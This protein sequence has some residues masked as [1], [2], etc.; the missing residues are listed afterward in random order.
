ML[1]TLVKASL[2]LAIAQLLVLALRHASAAAKH[3]LLTVG[4]AAF[5][6]MP[7]VAG[8]GPVWEV[9]YETQRVA[10]NDAFTSSSQ[11][12][13]VVDDGGP[14]GL[15]AGAPV[16]VWA[17]V[18]SVLMARL[19]VSAWRLRSIV[20]NATTPSPRILAMVDGE[21]VRVLC[22]DRVHVPMVWGLRTG[23]LLLPNAAEE[24]SDEELRATLIHELGHLQRLDYVS[25]G[26]MNV[27]TALLWFHP[28]VWIARRRALA[29]GER[30]CD[31]LVLRAGQRASTYAS[32]LLHV[33]R[34]APHREPLAAF[35]AMS[36]PSQLE[37][38]MLAILAPDTN[39]Q[40]IGGKRLMLA[41]TAFLA[42][43]VPL[44]VLQ[45]SA[46]P[47]PPAAPRAPHAAKPAPAP[48]AVV[49]TATVTLA[50]PPAPAP[51]SAK[52]PRAA[53]T[54][55]AVATPAPAAPV[56]TP[57]APTTPAPAAPAAPGMAAP[58]APVAV[59]PRAATPAPAAPVASPAPSARPAPAPRVPVAPA[60]VAVPAPSAPP[61]V[62]VQRAP[63]AEEM[64]VVTNAD[65]AARP[66]RSLGTLEARGYT[67]ALNRPVNTGDP[68]RNPAEVVATQR[69]VRAAAK[70]NADAIANLKCA[71]EI[72][73]GLAVPTAVVC[74]AEAIAFE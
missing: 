44:S 47:A 52:A 41:V 8:V 10:Q 40:A 39:R 22:S 16:V 36:R 71:R 50:A 31:D 42:V 18:A 25:L 28:Q 54:P 4:M 53:A 30:A 46:Q 66:H 38:R 48:H 65:L 37:G 59:P 32:H 62:P 15:E 73:I 20:A 12:I 60:P 27:V 72:R 19:V 70:K 14:A 51:R 69:L 5:V 13:A 17:L 1:L 3:L 56:A 35:L 11:T 26:L 7:I 67:L 29:E 9:T 74:S 43:I 24:W 33:A 23:T 68:S 49:G 58:A 64:L 63:D 21:R 57:S 34:L 45:I 55:V 61:A 2:V 6:V